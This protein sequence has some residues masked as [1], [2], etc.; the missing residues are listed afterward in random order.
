[1]AEFLCKF[2]LVAHIE[3]KQ[4]VSFV[5]FSFDFFHWY[6]GHQLVDLFR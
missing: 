4:G 3:Q 2:V 5:Q 1:M 6:A